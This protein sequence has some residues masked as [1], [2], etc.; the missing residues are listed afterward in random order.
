M[1]E[2]RPSESIKPFTVESYDVYYDGPWVQ[3]Y[4]F[5]GFSIAFGTGLSPA[6]QSCIPR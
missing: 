1:H 4:V 2:S 3:V 5:P 6:G